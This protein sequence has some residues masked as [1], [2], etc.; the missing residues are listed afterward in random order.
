MVVPQRDADLDPVL[1]DAFSIM[2]LARNSAHAHALV[3]M[4]SY[5]LE[6]GMYLG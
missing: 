2:R 1:I 6:D 4:G 5:T 3:S